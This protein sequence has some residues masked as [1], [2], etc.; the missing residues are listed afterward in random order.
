MNAFLSKGDTADTTADSG[1]DPPTRSPFRLHASGRTVDV[2]HIAATAGLDVQCFDRGVSDQAGHHRGRPLERGVT[3]RVGVVGHAPRVADVQRVAGG[4]RHRHYLGLG[5]HRFGHRIG[6][7]IVTLAKH[8]D[9]T[10]DN[11]ADQVF[12]RSLEI[13]FFALL[14]IYHPRVINLLARSC[15]KE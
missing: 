9:R 4:N 14:V 7:G 11:I 13:A 5:A 2:D 6:I 12:G 8:A 1:G 3:Q 10:Q 15:E